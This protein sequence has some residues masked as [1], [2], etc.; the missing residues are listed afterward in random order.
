MK[1]LAYKVKN[2]E[3]DVY[4]RDKTEKTHNES[5]CVLCL[6]VANYSENTAYDPAEEYENE[7]LCDLG[8]LFEGSGESLFG[9]HFI[10]P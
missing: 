8:E 5:G 4:R 7:N 3:N 2:P 6:S 1:N 10:S 9:S